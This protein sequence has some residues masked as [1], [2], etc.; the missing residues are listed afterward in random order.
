M[1]PSIENDLGSS[2]K[3]NDLLSIK[4]GLCEMKWFVGMFK[5]FYIFLQN[6]YEKV[7]QKVF[8]KPHQVF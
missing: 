4:K 5:W 6:D 3:R 1:R 2:V 8:I 7:L